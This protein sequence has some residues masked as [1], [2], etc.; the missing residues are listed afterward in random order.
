M[1]TVTDR[2]PRYPVSLRVL[3]IVWLLLMSTVVGCG[4][5]AQTTASVDPLLAT[6]GIYDI[7]MSDFLLAARSRTAPGEFPRSGSGFEA[8]RDRLLRDLMFETMLLVEARGRDLAISD[9]QLDA[10]LAQRRAELGAEQSE[11]ARTRELTE[12]FGSAAAYF[13]VVRRRMLI[14]RAEAEVRAELAADFEMSTAQL[15]EARRRLDSTLVQPAQLRAR[16]IFATDQ[17]TATEVH[18]QLARGA[19]FEELA[20]QQNGGSGDMGWMTLDSAPPLLVQV[21]EAMQDGDISE[22]HHSSLGY[23]IFQ[24]VGRRPTVPLSR[25]EG[26]VAAEKLLRNEYTESRFR[27]WLAQRSEELGVAVDDKTVGK[28]RCCLM[29]LPY[30]GKPGE[31]D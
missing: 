25:Q 4:A 18:S 26:R 11:G 31:K 20:R 29:G 24:L 6:L 13:E 12:R 3:G 7:E 9:Q 28:V 1:V 8:F 23:H 22:P 15:D 10:E 19:S 30:W 16:Q 21:A 17:Q 27:D 5:P 2:L 14:D